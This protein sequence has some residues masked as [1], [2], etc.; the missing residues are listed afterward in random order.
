[1][2]TARAQRRTL[3]GVVM[4]LLGV[5]LTAAALLLATRADRPAGSGDFGAA[6]NATVPP[7]TEAPASPALS[8]TATTPAA[9]AAPAPAPTPV[10]VPAPRELVIPRLGL[11]APIDRVGV[12]DDGQM[13]VPKDPDRVGWYRYSPAPGADRGSSVVVGH[14]DAKGLG[15]GVLYGLTEVRKGDRV[16]VV[17]DDGTTLTY[18][19]T[20]RRTL[21]KAALVRSAVFDR[22]G[23]A[24]LNLV[25]CAGPYLPDK[26]GYQNNLV[27]TAAEVP[28]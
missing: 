4:A 13:E 24:L 28:R 22:D 14:V 17:R 16:R 18:E 7:K 1:M 3:L 19:I 12:A 21:T 26:G 20:A 27:V 23:P 2:G 25:T 9:P 8:R 15:L 10:A 5:A 6:P 11:R